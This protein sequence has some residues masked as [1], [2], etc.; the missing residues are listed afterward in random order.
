MGHV[1]ATDLSLSGEWVPSP[2]V[3]SHRSEPMGPTSQSFSAR[4]QVTMRVSAFGIIGEGTPVLGYRKCPLD[5][6]QE[7]LPTRRLG[8]NCDLVSSNLIAIGAHWCFR[9]LIDLQPPHLVVRSVMRITL[10][11]TVATV[12]MDLLVFFHRHH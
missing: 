12:K 9:W 6:P 3:L 10:D 4:L 5:P 2:M 8:H 1:A 7:R 11:S